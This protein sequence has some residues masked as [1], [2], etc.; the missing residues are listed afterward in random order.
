MGALFIVPTNPFINVGLQR[1]EQKLATLANGDSSTEQDVVLTSQP[2]QLLISLSL[3]NGTHVGERRI[4]AVGTCEEQA[5]TVA[6]VI[7]T[8][9]ATR[10]RSNAIGHW[11][12][13][14]AP[15]FKP[16]DSSPPTTR[17]MLKSMPVVG[18]VSDPVSIEEQLLPAV[19]STREQPDPAPS[20]RRAS[21][22]VR[23]TPAQRSPANVGETLK[24]ENAAHDN[25]APET[26]TV[27]TPPDTPP[28]PSLKSTSRSD[29]ETPPPSPF[30]PMA[31]E[32][33][34]LTAALF[35]LRNAPAPQEALALLDAYAAAFPEG[36]LSA[37]ATITRV[38]ALLLLR[39][40]PEAL[41]ALK[42]LYTDALKQLPRAGELR[43]LVTELLA[44][45]SA[46]AEAL[47]ML[48]NLDFP[49]QSEALLD[50]VLFWQA[51]CLHQQKRHEEGNAVFRRSLQLFP[52]GRFAEII[53][54]SLS[55]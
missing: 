37:E 8:W 25:A 24:S 21:P 47:P 44:E 43:I 4:P 45:T 53:R 52:S 20:G 3:R 14:G 51:T 6:T 13:M 16:A 40:R 23:T 17:P 12:G 30:N 34:L 49:S 32:A 19:L 54:Q 42:S 18:Q 31:E 28:I 36:T 46:C 48:Q 7:A 29:Q 26:G 35:Q 38:D 27:A 15:V 55:Q 50:R 1:F 2:G 39:R 5:R 9:N 22:L 33:R 11:L 41:Q 10:P